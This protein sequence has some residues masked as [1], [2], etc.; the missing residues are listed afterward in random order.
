VRG[1]DIKPNQSMGSKSFLA[2]KDLRFRRVAYRMK[3]TP[4]NFVN[5]SEGFI[6]PAI[7]DA[8]SIAV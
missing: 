8:F 6:L 1:L 4:I 3:W 5:S 7:I 2:H